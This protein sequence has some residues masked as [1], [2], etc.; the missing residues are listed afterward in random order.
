M[1]RLIN[2]NGVLCAVQE[3][4]T[5]VICDLNELKAILIGRDEIV[6]ESEFAD[7]TIEYVRP[8]GCDGCKGCC[9]EDETRGEE[10]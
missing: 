5:E 8:A 10:E 7:I 1:I 4:T 3:N 2:D 6:V 9:R